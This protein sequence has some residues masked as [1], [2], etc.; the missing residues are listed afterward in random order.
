[1]PHKLKLDEFASWGIPQ[2]LSP[3]A[4]AGSYGKWMMRARIASFAL[5][6]GALLWASTLH[7]VDKDTVGPIPRECLPNYIYAHENNFCVQTCCVQ[8]GGVLDPDTVQLGRPPCQYD[9]AVC[10][11]LEEDFKY[12]RCFEQ[13]MQGLEVACVGDAAPPGAE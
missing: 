2:K 10:K 9:Y 13:C 11:S 1:M 4:I 7:A 3:R 6:L 12:S 8:S 5:G